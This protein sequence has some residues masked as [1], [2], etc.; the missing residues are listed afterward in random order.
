MRR[1]GK[2]VSRVIVAALC[3]AL[4]NPAVGVSYV[5][6]EEEP[7]LVYENGEGDKNKD[8]DNLDDD[9]NEDEPEEEKIPDGWNNIGP[10]RGYSYYKDNAPLKGWQ[11]IGK[12]KYYFDEN[13]EVKSGFYKI[14]G[15]LYY[16][17]NFSF[18]DAKNNKEEP[19]K[20][21]LIGERIGYHGYGNVYYIYEDLRVATGWKDIEGKM[22]YFDDNGVMQGGWRSK[23]GKWYYLSNSIDDYGAQTN[24]WVDGYYL[25]PNG[26]WEYEYKGAWY[27]D[28][29]GWWFEDENGWY[30]YSCWQKIDGSWYYF[31][32][33]G[34]MV[35]STWRN[36][37]GTYYYFNFDGTLQEKARTTTGEKTGQWIDGYWVDYSGAWTG[38]TASW[39]WDGTGYKMYDNNGW[40]PVNST[41]IIDNTYIQFNSQGYAT[42][43]DEILTNVPPMGGTGSAVKD[44]V[45]QYASRNLGFPYVY[46]GQTIAGTDCSGFT[47]LSWNSEGYNLPHN[48]GLQ[49]SY[50]SA[51]EVWISEVQP[52]DL[53]FYYSGD[54]ENDNGTGIGHVALYIGNGQTLEAG[55]QTN[56]R[57]WNADKAVYVTK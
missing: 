7:V 19:V 50:Y 24:C 16:L 47:M 42:Y 17:G 22:C 25:S 44:R 36:I 33:W 11:T 21:G 14:D 48:A 34:Y 20:T 43:W 6:A 55:D 30:P 2:M 39:T 57:R 45:I 49:Y 3:V 12:K 23:D 54:I 28:S 27:Q 40:S 1:L 13:G 29:W 26:V 4:V 9:Q 35:R 31:D 56:G 8:G 32:E 52:G 51:N 5:N 53:L 10:G 37:G 46:G 15:K 41:E 38:R 18:E